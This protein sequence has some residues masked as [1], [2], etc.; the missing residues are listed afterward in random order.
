MAKPFLRSGNLDDVLTLGENGQP[1]YALASQLR[2]ALRLQQQPAVADCLAIPILNA[3]GDRID[4]YAPI[5]GRAISWHAADDDA[6]SAALPLL[7]H[8]QIT[9][10]AISLRARHSGKANLQMFATLLSKAMQFPDQ[11]AVFLVDG[12]PVITFWGCVKADGKIRTAPLDCLRPKDR[13]APPIAPPIIE[14]VAEPIAEPQPP[15]PLPPVA[16]DKSHHAWW[17][18]LLPAAFI[19]AA[20]I[21]LLLPKPTPQEAIKTVEPVKIQPKPVITPAA[22]QLP[23]GYAEVQPPPVITPVVVDKLALTLPAEAVKIGSTAFLNGKWRVTLAI[24]DPLTGKPPSLLYQFNRGKGTA[25][26][27]QGDKVTCRVEVNAGLMQSGNLVIN[28]RTKARCSDGS[29]YQMPELVCK[30]GEAGTAAECTGRY[31]N[32]ETVFPMTIKRESK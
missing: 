29:R 17:L 13:P 3:Q 24:K 14:P 30:Q 6:R 20:A 32:N 9:A 10:E 27:V 1:V 21:W 8:F 16:D 5:A 19:L 25:R 12:K 22:L 11:N 4:W 23:L 2:E 18:L 15:A 28:S 7:E 26:I 31:G